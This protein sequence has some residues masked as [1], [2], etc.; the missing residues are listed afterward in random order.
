MK[1]IVVIGGGAAGF[2]S[3]I[4]IAEIHPDW[5]ISILEKSSKILSKVKVSGGGRCNVT[6]ACPDIEILLKKYPRGARFLKKAFYQF[7]TKNTI[8]WFAKNGVT[9]H[10]EKDGRMFP[11]TNNS[12]TIIECLLN[13]VKEYKIQ[14]LLHHEVVNIVK[15]NDGFFIELANNNKINSDAIC[16]ATGGMLKAN[17]LNWLIRLGHTIVEPVPS[18]FTFNTS[19][20]SITNLMGVAVENASIQWVGNKHIEQ[21]PL[22]ITHWGISGPAAIKLSAWCA[23]EMA[24]V[25]YEGHIAINWIPTYTEQ[26]LRMEWINLRLELGRKEMGGKNPFNLPNRLWLYF[27]QIAEINTSLKWA[28]LKST[29]Q[30]ILIQ[31][32]VRTTLP[33]KGK[34]T[35]KEEFVTCG[36]VDLSDIDAS[37]M[38]SKLVPGLHFAGEMMDVD[39]IT[40]GFNFQHAWTSGWI[41]AQHMGNMV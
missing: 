23:R 35:F 31:Q 20:K 1:K 41:A 12:E 36:G 6:H 22:L 5:D 18:L 15:T 16:M 4:Q 24:A 38:E 7:A 30:Q 21:G 2:F 10:T 29:Q 25:N 32:L 28:D 33:I 13:K 40:G 3:A 34:T 8:A 9:L 19:H 11:T 17:S 14:V 39:G 27:L 26:S 37:T